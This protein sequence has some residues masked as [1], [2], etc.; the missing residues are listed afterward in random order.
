MRRLRLVVL[1]DCAMHCTARTA[2]AEAGYLVSS[3][4]VGYDDG[5]ILFFDLSLKLFHC[6][7]SSSNWQRFR[8]NDGVALWRAEVHTA[9]S[10]QRHR[11]RGDGVDV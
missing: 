8:D 7:K 6:F 2:A 1:L 10:D 11:E 3:G 5:T 4:A 9:G